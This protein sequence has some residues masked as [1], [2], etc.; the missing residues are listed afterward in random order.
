M[1]IQT[2]KEFRDK[3]SQSILKDKLIYNDYNII[4]YAVSLLRDLEKVLRQAEWVW[5][6]TKVSQHEVIKSYSKRKSKWFL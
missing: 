3:S 5:G 4:W 2:W 6:I 1:G